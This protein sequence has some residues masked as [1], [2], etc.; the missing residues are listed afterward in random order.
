MTKT[1]LSASKFEMRWSIFLL[2]LM[3]LPAA[4]QLRRASATEMDGATKSLSSQPL[5][6]DIAKREIQRSQVMVLS[7]N[8]ILVPVRLEKS[9]PAPVAQ[10]GIAFVSKN[11]QPAIL[12][13]YGVGETETVSCTALK[14]MGST[15]SGPH[16]DLALI[17]E[18]YVDNHSVTEAVL[19]HR[20][21]GVYT[22]NEDACRYLSEHLQHVTIPA[23][24]SALRMRKSE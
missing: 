22:V 13:T 19:I 9:N 2:A 14:A 16:P 21:G 10:C 6:A 7:E 8:M 18:G 12:L 5:P 17:Y 11:A 15:S 20:A 24:R 1:K 23:V 3:S 4:A